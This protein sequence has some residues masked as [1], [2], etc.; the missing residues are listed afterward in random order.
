[1]RLGR[2]PRLLNSKGAG[3]ECDNPGAR[4]RAAPVIIGGKRGSL[5]PPTNLL[6]LLLPPSC[7]RRSNKHHRKYR[8]APPSAPAHSQSSPA[9]SAAL[10]PDFDKADAFSSTDPTR[11]VLLKLPRTSLVT[12]HPTPTPSR[13]WPSSSVATVSQRDRHL[14]CCRA[15]G[16]TVSSDSA[17]AP[18]R[19]QS[20]PSVHLLQKYT[21]P[22]QMAT[23]ALTSGAGDVIFQQ[24]IERKGWDKHEVR[25]LPL[26]RLELPSA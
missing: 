16:L 10:A 14:F 24:A 26:P 25:P 17:A 9:S 15:C 11:L 7:P 21:L 2:F 5:S 12:T 23:G 4:P 19:A 18:R 6:G 1:M 20:T 8:P 3:G 22:T 13:P